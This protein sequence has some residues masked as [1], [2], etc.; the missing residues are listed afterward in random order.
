MKR[1]PLR[2]KQGVKRTGWIKRKPKSSTLW[3]AQYHSE[4][5]VE[6]TRHAPSAVSGNL[7]CVA[8]HSA[9]TRGAGGTYR[10]IVP[11]TR[12][13]HEEEHRVGVRT[14]WA[15]YGKNPK[16]EAREHWK[17][18]CAYVEASGRTF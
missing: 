1:I 3:R 13:E 5:F 4:A 18:F 10:D 16:A 17:R 2:R 8:S 14:F 6:F 11:L 15:Q 7:G 9:K 12:A